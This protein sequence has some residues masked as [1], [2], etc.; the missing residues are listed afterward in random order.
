MRAYVLCGGLGTRL[1]SV[2]GDT[3]K[4]MVQVHGEP[5]LATVLRQLVQAGIVDVVLCAHYRAEQI[6]AAL[7]DLMQVSGAKLRMV[8]EPQLMG[9][10]GA[11]LHALRAQ[12]PAGRYLVLN[13]DTYLPAEAYALAGAASG[14]AILAV[15]V[16]ERA[17]YGS[18][19]IG[20][21]GGLQAIEE[22]GQQGPGLVN[23]GVYTFNAQA[24]AA[25]DV[26]AA[27]LERDLLPALLLRESVAVCEYAGGFIDIGT[28]ESFGR[29]AADHRVELSS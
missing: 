14:N 11:L 12:P 16:A 4:A 8:V 13:A 23:A 7:D 10:G 20:A 17:R 21:A 29:F 25:A 15:R 6:A 2:T 26:Q 9:T 18:L 3:Q 5:F 1:R 22:K 27:S 19:R 28:P 24:F